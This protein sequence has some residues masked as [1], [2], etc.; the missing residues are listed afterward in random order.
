MIAK[1][2]KFADYFLAREDNN[3]L[4]FMFI[5]IFYILELF[6]DLQILLD[7]KVQIKPGFLFPT[8]FW[9]AELNENI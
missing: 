8:Q 9:T 1:F 7:M 5:E 6:K 3:F 2:F 4:K